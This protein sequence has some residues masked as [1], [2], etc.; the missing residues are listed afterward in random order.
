M[1]TDKVLRSGEKVNHAIYMEGM[2]MKD[3]DHLSHAMGMNMKDNVS[4]KT[5]IF[6]AIL[7][8]II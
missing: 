6:V 4:L 8:I 5:K 3:S 2:N 1:G 7:S